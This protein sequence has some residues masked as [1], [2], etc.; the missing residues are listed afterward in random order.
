MIINKTLL[1]VKFKEYYDN[2]RETATYVFIYSQYQKEI[3]QGF[4]P[5]RVNYVFG[6][7]YTEMRS[8]DAN[9]CFGHEDSVF[10]CVGRLKD[11]NK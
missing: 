10:I 4:N 1:E 5:A 3:G 2:N 11:V 6:K 9:D 7:E 8:R